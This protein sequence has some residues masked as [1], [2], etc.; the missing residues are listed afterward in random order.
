M[1]RNLFKAWLKGL[2]QDNEALG[3]KLR[4]TSGSSQRHVFVKHAHDFAK[5]H[6][7]MPKRLTQLALSVVDVECLLRL[8][9]LGTLEFLAPNESSTKG[10]AS[11]SRVRLEGLL[12]SMGIQPERSVDLKAKDTAKAPDSAASQASLLNLE[13]LFSEE[14]PWL[15]CHQQTPQ[16]L[17]I[18]G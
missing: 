6:A 4:F 13:E 10:L 7:V 12:M 5:S 11:P 3:N 2:G 1:L 9:S 18:P 16:F 8:G 14:Q 17:I 15:G